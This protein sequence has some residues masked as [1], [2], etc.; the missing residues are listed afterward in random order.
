VTLSSTPLPVSE[1]SASFVL[2]NPSLPLE[3]VNII[4]IC[5]YRLFA[6]VTDAYTFDSLDIA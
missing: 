5:I 6:C 4:G 2:A 3:L 1:L